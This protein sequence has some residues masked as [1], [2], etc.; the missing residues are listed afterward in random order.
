M[1]E[2]TRRG[3]F[4]A[5]S[6][7]LVGAALADTT[8]AA[9][10]PPVV[11]SVPTTIPAFS[12]VQQPKPLSFDPAKL[13]G[14]SEKLMRS[15]WENNYTGSAKTL[16]AVKQK[17]AQ[18]LA[19]K[20]TPPFVYNDIKCEPL[21][22]TGSVVFHE[23]YFENLGCDGSADLETRKQI[24]TTFGDFDTWQTEFRTIGLGLGGGSDWVGV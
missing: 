24:G 16:N 12:V 10:N 23:L 9:D 3:I 14:R 5:A 19:D 8:S 15:H 7:A 20:N 1:T 21:M 6:S 13:N 4:Q 2:T 22:R 11:A 18:A 17:L